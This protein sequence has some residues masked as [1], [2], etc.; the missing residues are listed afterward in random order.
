MPLASCRSL[1]R[2]LTFGESPVAFFV[3][4]VSLQQPPIRPLKLSIILADD[5]SWKAFYNR[6]GGDFL[7]LG[8]QGTGL[9]EGVFADGAVVT[10]GG[11]RLYDGGPADGGAVDYAG[12][13]DDD[14][15]L[16][17]ELVVGQEVE[18]GV[19]QD[20]D[21][22]ADADGAVGVADNFDSGGN[23]AVLA[24]DDIACDLGGFT[25]VGGVGY[26]GCLVFVGIQLAH[27]ISFLSIN[28]GQL[29]FFDVE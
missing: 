9:D 27:G 19:F 8:D 24:D 23:L 29:A 16:D 21:V 5:V 11:P 25:E 13:T 4:S 20:L 1:D 14:V 15:V 6:I 17:D 10:E 26:L 22:V 28:G 18:D 7:A 12:G 2:N 3:Q